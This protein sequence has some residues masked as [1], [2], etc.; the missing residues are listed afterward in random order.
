M[1]KIFSFLPTKRIYLSYY[2]Y[3]SYMQKFLL[4]I[5]AMTFI[6]AKASEEDIGIGDWRVHLP[7]VST[8]SVTESEHYVYYATSGSIF[9]IDK[10]DNS[11]Q[12]YSKPDGLTDFGLSVIRYYAP[13]DLLLVGYNNGNVDF[14]NDDEVINIADIKNKNMTGNKGINDIVFRSDTAY[15][16]CGFGVVVVDM[17][18]KEIINT[19][20]IGDEGMAVNVR[21]V[22]FFEDHIY[23]L[24][25]DGLKYAD[26]NAINLADFNFWSDVYV[27]DD[28]VSVNYDGLVVWNNQLTTSFKDTV[29]Q[30]DGE[31]WSKTF[32]SPIDKGIEDLFVHGS[33]MSIFQRLDSV[34]GSEPDRQW[35]FMDTN[36]DT[37]SFTYSNY[38]IPKDILH[39][40]DGRIYV[41]DS[42]VGA[43]KIDGGTMSTIRPN[44]PNSNDVYNF[45]Y[46]NNTMFVAT[47]GVTTS[48]GF[49]WNSRGVYT[50]S[51]SSWWGI[52]TQGMREWG[53]YD[54]LD[55]VYNPV[56]ESYYFA[57]Y[58][59][60]LLEYKGGKVI[61]GIKDSIWEYQDGQ[62]V[63]T[64]KTSLKAVTGHETS[65]RI[66]SLVMDN[67]NN[68]WFPSYESSRPMNVLTA[69]GEIYSY[70]PKVT[71]DGNYT[72][73]MVIDEA[74]NKWT[75]SPRGRG[76]IVFNE[77][78]T[79]DDTSDDDWVLL[80]NSA[81]TGN[82][83]SV[84][85][86][87]IA[88]DE[89]GEIWVATANGIAV[90]YC[91]EIIFSSGCNAQKINIEK[92]GYLAYAFDETLVTSIEVDG[93]NRK[94]IG[95]EQGVYL[96]SDDGTEELL[97][98]NSTNSPLLSDIIV[99]I[100]INHGTGEVFFGTDKGVISYKST[101]TKTPESSEVL[102]YPNPV[103]PDYDGSLAVRGIPDNSDVKITDI[104]GNIV[105][106]GIALGGQAI[107]DLKGQN[108]E[109]VSSGMYLVWA[110][111]EDGSQTEVT[112]VLIMK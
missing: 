7:F 100:G 89:D 19:Y 13:E 56:N 92:D 15:L 72:S 2:R 67:Q 62:Y 9:S 55:V 27:T 5:I 64:E 39:L 97:Q 106:H 80:T 57:S 86:Y 10:L 33:K 79:F 83:P 70:S 90:F 3:F 6:L 4:F 18:K 111:N 93:A 12:K 25:D 1:D 82:L 54:V 95:T 65:Y 107:W 24:T 49:K 47:G 112:K 71:I 81:S 87:D 99:D 42:Y 48:W 40:D 45:Y 23:A 91:P 21:R 68:L 102:V 74:G 73:K 77:N 98:F 50:F 88:V 28:S 66:T 35:L 26:L 30:Y 37:S 8:H 110:T 34:N 60:G 75:V 85:I 31:N 32:E 78:G 51:G 61:R 14:F 29:Y 109:R 22:N 108:G 52:Y 41:A 43:Y 103:R 20:F 44:G 17:T 76:I 38:S 84:D 36:M 59:H 69:E 63:A 58:G 46:A 105:Y 53:F 11:I 101:A 94:W 104:A 16:S 96:M